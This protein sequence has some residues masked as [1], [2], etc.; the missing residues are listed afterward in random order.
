MAFPRWRRNFYVCQR[1]HCYMTN[2]RIVFEGK[3][4]QIAIP[5]SEL[6]SF[7]VAPGGLVFEGSGPTLL[8]T[9][10]NPLIAAAVLRFVKDGASAHE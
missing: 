2:R 5:F 3:D 7:S 1:T 9:F 10:Q 6:K 4:L 8:F